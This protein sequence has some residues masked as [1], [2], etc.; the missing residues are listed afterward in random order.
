MKVKD[1]ARQLS[2]KTSRFAGSQVPTGK[3]N[4]ESKNR[5]FPTWREVLPYKNI[6]V[7]RDAFISGD[8]LQ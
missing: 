5:D 3:E 6:F 4:V 7:S 1:Y 8:Y 2:L